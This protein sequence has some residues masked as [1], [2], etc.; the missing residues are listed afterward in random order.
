[1]KAR[2]LN[3][4]EEKE[5]NLTEAGISYLKKR[6]DDELSS[7]L[8]FVQRTFITISSHKA[9]SITWIYYRIR[10]LW[11]AQNNHDLPPWELYD[12]VKSR[13]RALVEWVDFELYPA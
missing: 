11:R 10:N 8:W 2:P 12:V 1:M 13:R 9:G 3:R 5:L 7:F 4:A 6:R